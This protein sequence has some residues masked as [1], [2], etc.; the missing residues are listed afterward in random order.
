MKEYKGYKVFEDGTIIGKLNKQLKPRIRGNYYSIRIHQG[1][2]KKGNELIHRIVATLYVP[3]IEG[4][5]FVNHKNG[6]K[7]DNRAINL[8]WTNR[9]ENQKH[10]YQLG[11]QKPKYGKNHQNYKHGKYSK[12]KTIEHA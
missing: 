3:K 12:Y 5:D 8:E 11:L 6:N 10:A 9:S 7:L 4:K 2:I 1:D